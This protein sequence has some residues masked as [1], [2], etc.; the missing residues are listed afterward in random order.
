MRARYQTPARPGIDSP[1]A[2]A[3]AAIFL[4]GCSDD[5]FARITPESL[6][7]TYRLSERRA[8]YELTVATQKR[9]KMREALGGV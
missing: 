4:F 5:A 3:G 7:R 1:D 2:L 9:A 6:A 8:G